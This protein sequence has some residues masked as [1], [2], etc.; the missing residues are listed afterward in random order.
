MSNK[1]LTSSQKILNNVGNLSEVTK[2]SALTTSDLASRA[3]E[4][5]KT[6]AV[7][8]AK[9][10]GQMA[11]STLSTAAQSINKY[12][13]D[14]YDVGGNGT[15]DLTADGGAF[16]AG[17]TAMVAD[18]AIKM[19][20]VPIKK[21]ME[22]VSDNWYSE[23]RL[24]NANALQK[25]MQAKDPNIKLSKFDIATRHSRN[26]IFDYKDKLVFNR[27]SHN[28][29]NSVS[30]QASLLK[31]QFKANKYDRLLK[32]KNFLKARAGKMKTFSLRSS[33]KGM[34]TNQYRKLSSMMI[35]GND[36]NSM[37]SKAFSYANNAMRYTYAN[38]RIFK[39][40]FK[41]AGKVIKGS[42]RT[43]LHPIQAIR[44]LA[45]AIVSVLS[46]IIGIITSIPIVVSIIVSVLPIIIMCIIMSLIVSTVLSW[47][48]ITRDSCQVYKN[49][50]VCDLGNKVKDLAEETTIT[51]TGSEQY[52]LMFK[53]K[54]GVVKHDD[55]GLAYIEENGIKYYCNAL[56]T[57]YTATIGSRWKVTL[58][59]GTV[60]YTIT[61]DIKDDKHTRA[62]NNDDSPNCKSMDGSMLEFYGHYN[63]VTLPKLH[64][65]GFY[66]INN[67]LD[68]EH[69]WKSPV[70]KMERMSDT[71]SCV[72]ASK[73]YVK[74]MIEIAND[75]THGYSQSTKADSGAG[76]QF[77]PD[78][79][80]SSFVYYALL[81]NGMT[82]DQLTTYPFTTWSMGTILTKPG[83]GF[84]E[85]TYNDV[86]NNLQEG[87]I[88]VSNV[89]GLEHTEVYIGNGMT[90][91]AHGGNQ[92]RKPG[93]SSG[94]E[95]SI[96]PN[97][98]H[99]SLNAGNYWQHV[100]RPN[101][102]KK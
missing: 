71:K 101:P 89:K 33:T 50:K 78:V 97:S 55:W 74:W 25:S 99:E 26:S 98:T 64:L 27:W 34:I 85:Y 11:S 79:D 15:R 68:E 16:I 38:R 1:P 20:K 22:I 47:F 9:S 21:G 84:K 28:G 37:E 24:D 42:V 3:A 41:G 51:D 12:T 100:Y 62:G 94:N 7:N 5:V 18:N 56:G 54:Y 88:L 66:S 48:A 35:R 69:M 17:N 81:N 49:V 83:S 46:S 44:R 77:N 31:K 61:C 10:T 30:Q 95:I 23:K 60:I 52:Q 58:E 86:K 14:V 13:P 67:D 45:S 91:G 6:A 73:D 32:R 4:N 70:A 53:N 29:I 8:V 92:D 93:D 59:N 57:Y 87:D 102:T 36:P 82:T 96:I 43:A 65:A 90:V 39:K 19:A 76:R 2:Q 63:T 75:N 72:A 40:M 80:C